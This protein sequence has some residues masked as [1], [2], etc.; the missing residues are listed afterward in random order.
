MPTY[1]GSKYI[2]EQ[3]SSILYQLGVDD[4]IVVS[5]DSSSD[6]TVQIVEEFADS[7]IRVFKENTFHSP[8]YNF[9]NALKH[10]RGDY[11]FMADQDDVWTSD[12]VSVMMSFLKKTDLVV[13]DCFIIDESG[14]EEIGSFYFIKRSGSGFFKN[15][16]KNSYIGCCMA[17]NRRIA[18]VIIPFPRNLAM[19]DV[20]IGLLAELIGDTVFIDN[21]LVYYRH[22]ANNCSSTATFKS[23]YSF[24][25]KIW[26]R[27]VLLFFVM[28]RYFKVLFKRY[29][30]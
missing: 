14:N 12:K 25:Y 16:Y 7:R 30:S 5:D 2:R 24:C 18:E 29:E 6:E 9:E 13:S 27:S 23:K 21:K 15:L 22:H 19:H 28:M 4:E 8:V 26:Y 1:N 20:W 17:F 3:I 10:A 11:I